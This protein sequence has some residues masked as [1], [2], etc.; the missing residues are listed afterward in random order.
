MRISVIGLGKI[1]LPLAAQFASKGNSVTGVDLNNEIVRL[2]NLGLEPFPGEMGLQATIKKSVAARLLTATADYSVAIPSADVVLV[3]VPLLI[4][5]G[6]EPDFEWIDSATKSIGAFL[7]KNTL[8]LYETTLPIGT[9][10]KRWKPML[11]GSSGLSEGTDFHVVFSPE[12]VLTGRVFEDLR[13]YPKL[14]GGLSDRGA[15]RARD[16][17]DSVLDFDSRS[18]L[19]R[20]NGV[21]DLGSAEAAEMAK[22]AET[23]YRDVNIALANQFALHAEEIG[24]DVHKVIEAC[25]SQPYS[26]IHQPGISVG[27]HCIPVYPRLYAFTD[28][29]SDIVAVARKRNLSMPAIA[30]ESLELAM[31]SLKDIKVLVLGVSYRAGVKETAFSGSFSLV[32]E[33]ESRGAVVSVLD[34]QYSAEEL[35]QLGLLECP[36]NTW[37]ESIVLHTDHPHFKDVSRSDFPNV[38]QI[39]DGRHFLDETK[40]EGVKV[41]KIGVGTSR[42]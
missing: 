17:Y 1:G 14:I 16:F 25:N 20:P 3:T 22:L 37:P 34:P 9:T 15:S 36:S 10:R 42:I 6:D 21:W 12:R 26:H 38:T 30:V 11:E 23:I 2:V 35:M 40:W 4:D 27:G 19:A 32:K 7:K 8:V 41:Q 29:H 31:G 33:L 28:K 24:V 13:K 18:D 5:S 39:Y